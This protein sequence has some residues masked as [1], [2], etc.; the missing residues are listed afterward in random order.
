MSPHKSG[1]E[2][3]APAPQNVTVFRIFKEVM[4]VKWDIECRPPFN[5]ADVLTRRGKK[6]TKNKKPT[7]NTHEGTERR[8]LSVSQGGGSLRGNYPAH[9]LILDVHPPEP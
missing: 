4:K 7:R 8:G 2:T 3:L 5:M 6:E 1:V 9:I